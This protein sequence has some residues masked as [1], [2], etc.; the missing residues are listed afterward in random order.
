MAEMSRELIEY[1]LKWSWTP[2]R[3]LRS[4]RASDVLVVR[5]SI[6]TT[7]VG[8]GIMSYRK[9]KANLSLLAVNVNRR[10]SGV[11]KAILEVLEERAVKEE[12]EDFYVQVRET[13]SGAQ[14]FYL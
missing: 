2:E 6:R 5:A 11:G 14:E 3:V 12:I 10:R 13:N 9:E 1:D 4:I 8:F 7:L